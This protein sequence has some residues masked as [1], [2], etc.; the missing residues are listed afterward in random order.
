MIWDQHIHPIASHFGFKRVPEEEVL[1]KSIPLPRTIKY[2]NG[3]GYY[4]DF[5]PRYLSRS[6]CLFH[7]SMKC[8]ETKT[9]TDLEQLFN[10]LD[11]LPVFL[12]IR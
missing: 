1:F 9:F 7:S 8:V 11:N 6:E 4:L 5:I 3:F 2:E 10:T 12:K